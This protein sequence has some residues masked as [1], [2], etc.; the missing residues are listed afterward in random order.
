MMTSHRP[1]V[2]P[3]VEV[4]PKRCLEQ[5]STTIS[6]SL[7]LN[8]RLMMSC[9]GIDLVFE[10]AKH[11]STYHKIYLELG[12]RGKSKLFHGVRQPIE[13]SRLEGISCVLSTTMRYQIS[14]FFAGPSYIE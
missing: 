5:Q 9:G 2:E 4:D 12:S 1:A 13:T 7:P 8:F 3:A 10:Q 6:K 11:I 14:A